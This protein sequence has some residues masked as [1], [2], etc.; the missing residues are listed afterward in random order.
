MESRAGAFT[1]VVELLQVVVTSAGCVTRAP[2][3]V[4]GCEVDGVLKFEK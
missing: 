3:M 2:F 1:V 4:L